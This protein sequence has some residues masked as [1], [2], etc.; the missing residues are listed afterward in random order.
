MNI[1]ATKQA[2]TLSKISGDL[3]AVGVHCGDANAALEII[4]VNFLECLNDLRNGSVSEV[5]VHREADIAAQRQE[6]RLFGELL[7]PV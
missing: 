2:W 6:R 1:P 7:A 4:S 3:F 5:V